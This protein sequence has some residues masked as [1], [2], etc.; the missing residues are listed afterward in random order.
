MKNLYTFLFLTLD[1]LII[2]CACAGRSGIAHSGSD[3]AVS[4][5]SL[6]PVTVSYATGFTIRDSAGVRL[7]DVGSHD[8]FALV[9]SEDVAVPEGYTK[10]RVPVKRTICMTA[11]Q[12]S[13]FTVTS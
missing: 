4:A 11:L 3:E 7:V 5:D 6:V 10:V 2:L 13:N 12:L 8:R 9:H 1:S